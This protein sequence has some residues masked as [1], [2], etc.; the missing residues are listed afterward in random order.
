MT[1]YQFLLRL[2]HYRDVNIA[3]VAAAVG[4]HAGTLGRWEKTAREGGEPN[5]TY[6]QLIAWASALG[7]NEIQAARINSGSLDDDELASLAFELSRIEDVGS[8][9]DKFGL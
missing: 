3:D 2:R 6:Q 4:V 9:L 5:A 1:I 7:V 8:I